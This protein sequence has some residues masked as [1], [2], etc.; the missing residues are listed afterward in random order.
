MAKINTVETSLGN[1]LNNTQALSQTLSRS[2]SKS[3]LDSIN[4]E[5]LVSVDITQ[6]KSTKTE[7]SNIDCEGND[8]N[9]LDQNTVVRG[10]HVVQLYAK[11]YNHPLYR[12]I[13]FFSIF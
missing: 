3:S 13:L 10:I 4:E 8:I 1:G 11:H 12:I 9:N 7:E 2:S 5:K 6:K